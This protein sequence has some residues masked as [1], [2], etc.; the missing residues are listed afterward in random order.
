MHPCVVPK[1][2]QMANQTTA[3]PDFLLGTAVML[4][5]RNL[6]VSI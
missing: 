4:A 5:V 6:E 1:E 2:I 3:F